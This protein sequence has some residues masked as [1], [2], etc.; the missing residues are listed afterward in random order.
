MI[1]LRLKCAFEYPHRLPVIM[2]FISLHFQR[3]DRQSAQWSSPTWAS[4]KNSGWFHI[5][6]VNL[7]PI[8]SFLQRSLV[9]SV[10]IGNAN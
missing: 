7:H 8:I 5:C 4:Q 10:E 2:I 3:F 6:E 9:C 1:N